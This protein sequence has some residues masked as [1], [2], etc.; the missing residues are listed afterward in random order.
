MC[1]NTKNGYTHRKS[2]S[3]MRRLGHPARSSLPIPLYHV[4]TTICWQLG[5]ATNWGYVK[6]IN[7]I[8][9]RTC[10]VSAMQCGQ[11]AM[12][13]QRVIRDQYPIV[14]RERLWGDAPCK[15]NIDWLT[16]R[17]PENCFLKK[18]LRMLLVSASYSETADHCTRVR[19]LLRPIS[20]TKNNNTVVC[21]TAIP[22]SKRRR[23][24]ICNLNWV[25]REIL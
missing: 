22:G 6:M 10:C 16:L 7:V 12:L 15:V 8:Q 2:P 23:W 1:R 17:F 9:I 25:V 4:L 24:V 18:V 21:H 13:T 19:E 11:C 14:A 20:E 3:N 5:W